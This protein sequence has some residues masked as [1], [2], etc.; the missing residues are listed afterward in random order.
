[1]SRHQR[2][3]RR[4][5]RVWMAV[6]GLILLGLTAWVLRP[7]TSN[8]DLAAPG[9]G[10]GQGRPVLDVPASEVPTKDQVMGLSGLR[11]GLSAPQV[12]WSGTELDRLSTAAGA[13]PTML[14]F[15]VKW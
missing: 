14:Q 9:A 7:V 13:R 3:S 6:N 12:P 8:S 15:F 10:G 11:F 1:M 4:R 2:L 5:L